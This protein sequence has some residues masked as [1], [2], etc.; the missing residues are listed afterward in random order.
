MD[1]DND[2]E[3]NK[4]N[5][6]AVNRTF[7]ILNTMIEGP[8][9][10]TQIATITEIHKATVLRFLN[11]LQALGYITKNVKTETFQLSPKLNN[12]YVASKDFEYLKK[13]IYPFLLKIAKETQET[14]HLALLENCQLKYLEKIESRQSLRVVTS[15]YEGGTAPLYCTGLGKVLLAYQEVLERNKI[16]ETIN[17]VNFTKNTLTEIKALNKELD[18]IYKQ[19]FAFDNEEHEEGIYCIA[20]PILKNQKAVAA[21]SITGPSFRMLNNRTEFIAL[22]QAYQREIELLL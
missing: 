18:S 4:Y 15:S 19:G 1:T 13:L 22:L 17:F 7:S 12:F 9:T 21:I 2:Q 11:T 6:S 10:L 5:V 8:K 14:I 3:N 16:I 20:V